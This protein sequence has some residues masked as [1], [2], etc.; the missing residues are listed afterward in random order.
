M[1]ALALTTD[2][3]KLE[4][5]TVPVELINPPVNMLPPVTLPVTDKLASVPTVVKLEYKTFELKVLPISALALTLEAAT[6][7]N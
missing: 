6:P 4:P 5:V 2:P 3:N 1:L 7:V